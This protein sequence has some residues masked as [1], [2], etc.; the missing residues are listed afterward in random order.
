MKKANKWPWIVAGIIIILA[1]VFFTR[2]GNSDP[3][4]YDTFAQCVTESGAKM[5]GAY[6]CPHCQDQKD[7]FGSS[8]KKINYVECD[9][10]GDNANP[11]ACEAAGIQGYP[12]WVFGDDEHVPGTLQLSVIADKTG[13]QL[14]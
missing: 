9:P 2:N 7:M 12:T 8:W 10:R 6:W 1:I 14:P 3:G 13:C 4:K 5:F 11:D